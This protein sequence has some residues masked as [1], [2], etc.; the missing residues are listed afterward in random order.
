MTKFKIN[1]QFGS[2][3][4]TKNIEFE[5]DKSLKDIQKIEDNIIYLSNNK[6]IIIE[7]ATHATRVNIKK[8]KNIKLNFNIPDHSSHSSISLFV[9]IEE[10]QKNDTYE[11]IEIYP[12][13]YHIKEKVKES[14]PGKLNIYPSFLNINEDC[15]ININSEKNKK[16]IFSINDKRINVLT[17]NDGN[18]SIRFRGGDILDNKNIPVVQ[19]YPI[20]FYISKDNFTKQNFSGSYLHILPSSIKTTTSDKNIDPR[21]LEEDYVPG[22][23]TIPEHCIESPEPPPEPI[24]E[25]TNPPNAIPTKTECN[26]DFEIP[27]EDICRISNHDSTLI[28]NGMVLHSYVS[29]DPDI[30][31]NSHPDYN[32]PRV[33]IAKDE[34]SIEV[35][36]ITN[37]N[38]IIGPKVVTD[39]FTL[40]IKDDLWDEMADYASKI[41]YIVIFNEIFGYQSLRIKGREEFFS[42]SDNNILKILIADKGTTDVALNG[43]VFCENATIYENKEPILND[44]DVRKIPFV[45]DSLGNALPVINCSITS[46]YQYVED[47]KSIKTYLI[48]EAY[49]NNESQLFLF[50]FS[51][52]E[53]DAS[54]RIDNWK[55]LTTSG[56]NKNPKAYMDINNNLNIFWESDRSGQSQIYYGLLG[57]ST[58]SRC[59]TILA[60]MID[61]QADVLQN[62]DRSFYYTEQNILIPAPSDEYNLMPLYDTDDLINTGWDNNTNNN[63]TIT[64]TT[65]ENY[66]NNIIINGNPID[67]TA[68]AFVSVEQDNFASTSGEFNYSQFNYQINF[69]LEV[70]LSQSSSLLTDENISELLNPLNLDIV[71]NN[72]KSKFTTIIN[73]SMSNTPVYEYNNNTFILG[74]KDNIYD[75]FVPMVG[76]Y[77]KNYMSDLKIK[78]AQNENSVKHFVL[79]LMF[80][81]SYF[82]AINIQTREEYDV[83][84]NSNDYIEKEEHVLYTGNAK[85][86]ILL[87]TNQETSENVISDDKS[88]YIIIKEFPQK[89]NIYNSNNFEIIISYS[90]LYYEE[91]NTILNKPETESNARFLC[92]IYLLMNKNIKFSESF[93]V[94]LSDKYRKF[95]LGFGIPSGGMYESDKRFPNKLAVYDNIL[96]TLSFADIKI[97]SPTYIYNNDEIVS[98]SSTMKSLIEI[99][100]EDIYEQEENLSKFYK[101]YFNFLTF[102]TTGLNPS[103]TSGTPT[104]FQIPITMEGINKSVNA[105]IG[106]CDDINICWQSNRNKYWNIYY[107]NFVDNKL[108]FRIETKITDTESNS[109]MPAIEINR[110]GKR[111][112]T[113][114]DNRDGNYEI[115]GAR[116]LSGYNYNKERCKS[117]MLEKYKPDVTSCIV[118]IDY[119]CTENGLYHFSLEFYKD[120]SLTNLFTTISTQNN[121]DGWQVGEVSF[122]S[123]CIYSGETCIGISLTNGQNIMI[124]YIPQRG[125]IIFDKVLYTKLLGIIE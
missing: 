72:W 28:A 99:Y 62:I 124:S 102:D 32:I 119:T 56:N 71:Y 31:E 106:L 111:L 91:A 78:F 49:I 67:D 41:Y 27:I 89:F 74:R 44:D 33:Y 26:D 20:Y 40:Y 3:R 4:D 84:H 114:Q 2:L 22:E 17:N 18:G 19:K 12:I 54:T 13:I 37:R 11:L 101:D 57:P 65:G 96:T 8:D 77:N 83:E 48:A 110:N 10:K 75:R 16:Y 45:R 109:I 9:N 79:G 69:N 86:V 113:W 116:S 15:S 125:D 103:V 81:K 73:E 38:I 21:C 25:P 97:T 53:I 39:D 59:G 68:L 35:Q 46:N 82:K 51:L 95:D 98:V 50:S 115:Y 42:T 43:Y 1:P 63:G 66:L 70:K 122:E 52:N 107:S 90:K 118:E 108:P 60:S 14:F 120:N 123:L 92:N 117:I 64:E 85:L 6:R 36:V 47:E 58:T 100:H 55:Q 94:D 24:P 61:K 80:E 104:F 93:L 88:D 29:V 34:S 105:S 76:S 112:I 23:W 30:A 87:K 5:I 121:I 7:N